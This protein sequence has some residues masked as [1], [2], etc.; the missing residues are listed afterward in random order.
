VVAAVKAW[1]SIRVRQANESQQHHG[2]RRKHGGRTRDRLADELPSALGWM[3]LALEL[4]VAVVVKAN[5]D[6]TRGN[7]REHQGL[8]RPDAAD[9][10]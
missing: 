8:Q 1:M 7:E 9:P 4:D 6:D 2:T 5:A 3:K 10:G